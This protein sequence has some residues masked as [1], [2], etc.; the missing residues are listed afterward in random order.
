MAPRLRWTRRRRFASSPDQNSGVGEP[1]NNTFVVWRLILDAASL[2]LDSASCRVQAPE[3]SSPRQRRE[4]FRRVPDWTMDCYRVQRGNA[5]NADA[6]AKRIQAEF[7]EMPGLTLTV[8]QASRLF[9]LDRE[10][11]RDVIDELVR[12]AYLRRTKTGVI[13]REDR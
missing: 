6:V 3:M 5:M 10:I 8:S 13:T 7:E 11:C 2:T 9:G 1:P 4:G 12:R